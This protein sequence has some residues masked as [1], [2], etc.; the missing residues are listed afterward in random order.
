MVTKNG[1]R[2]TMLLMQDTA[3]LLRRAQR[4]EEHEVTTAS[5]GIGAVDLNLTPSLDARRHSHPLLLPSVRPRE[6]NK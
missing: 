2:D 4:P 6:R 1:K 3:C 5:L